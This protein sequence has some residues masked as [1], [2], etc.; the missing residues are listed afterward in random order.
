MIGAWPFTL[1]EGRERGNIES[2]EQVIW[3]QTAASSFVPS[4][5]R[6]ELDRFLFPPPLGG[7]LGWGAQES[8][9]E[10]TTGF[11]Q[12]FFKAFR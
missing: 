9:R 7:G 11:I 5:F 1:N 8:N 4:S 3:L 2:S 10:K 12:R 6:G